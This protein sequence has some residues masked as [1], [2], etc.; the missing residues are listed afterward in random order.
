MDNILRALKQQGVQT[1]QQLLNE[2]SEAMCKEAL[3]A[4]G[5]KHPTPSASQLDGYRK[6]LQSGYDHEHILL[7]CELNREANRRSMRD[8]FSTLQRWQTL[9]L[10]DGKSIRNHEKDRRQ[11]IALLEQA[12]TCMGLNRRVQEADLD[13]Y[14]TWTKTWKL[15]AELVLFAAE[16][17]HGANS[18]YRM[19]KKLMQDWHESGIKSVAGGAQANQIDQAGKSQ[20]PGAELPAA[21]GGRRSA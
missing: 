11:N 20:K 17:S 14:H 9:G 4:L 16:C 15:P 7:A 10:T 18:P 6:W 21:S 2:N 13:L 1:P 12:F 5:L 3:T 8:V 19:V